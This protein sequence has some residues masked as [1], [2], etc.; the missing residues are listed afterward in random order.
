MASQ[1]MNDLLRAPFCNICMSYVDTFIEENVRI[2]NESGV[3]SVIIRQVL[4]NCCDWCRN[5]AGTYDADDAPNDIYRRHDNC[6]CSVIFKSD[7]S[8]Y[9]NVHTKKTF[10]KYKD[11]RIDAQNLENIPVDGKIKKRRKREDNEAGE[12]LALRRLRVMYTEGRGDNSNMDII[13]KILSGEISIK[14]RQQKYLQH[15]IGTPQY[16]SA[17][18]GRK[19]AQSY[20]NDGI[21]EE[22]AQDIIMSKCGT[23]I[24]DIG[25]GHIR[26]YLN[27]DEPIGFYYNGSD[28]IATRRIM[29]DYSPSGAHIV[30]VKEK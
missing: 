25:D 10:S 2:R 26:E 18:K 30:P 9:T 1:Q 3:H 19:K 6:K 17:T 21:S 11:A 4:G 8:A 13:E 28:W 20:L 15:K 27:L 14:Q 29:I 22:N 12:M 24:P 23:G 7:K 16:N 5:L